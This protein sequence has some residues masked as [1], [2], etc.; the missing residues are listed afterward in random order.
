MP[1]NTSTAWLRTGDQRPTI[2]LASIRP[3]PLD[4]YPYRVQR[5]SDTVVISA[6]VPNDADDQPIGFRPV[7]REA[8]Q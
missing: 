7:A 2:G 3:R 5:H 4:S 1:G 6:M 8:L